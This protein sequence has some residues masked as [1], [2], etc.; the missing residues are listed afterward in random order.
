MGVLQALGMGFPM[1]EEMEKKKKEAKAVACGDESQSKSREKLRKL[2]KEK[3][4]DLSFSVKD[5]PTRRLALI[6]K[7]P[8]PLAFT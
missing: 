7:L 3:G 5:F 6:L 8:S 4:G 2:R 1:I